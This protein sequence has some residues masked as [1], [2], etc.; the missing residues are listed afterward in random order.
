LVLFQV[1]VK[2]ENFSQISSDSDH[3]WLLKTSLSG[4]SDHTSYLQALPDIDLPVVVPTRAITA[5]PAAGYP[6][7]FITPSTLP[8]VAGQAPGTYTVWTRT[9]APNA[10]GDSL[11]VGLDGPFGSTQDKQLVGVTGVEPGQ[12]AWANERLPA[13]QAATLSIETGGLYTLTASMRED[14]LRLDRLV[15]TTD[16]TPSVPTGEGPL[17]TTRQLTAATTTTALTRTIVYTYD[18]LSRLTAVDYST[19]ESFAY[20]YDPLG[21]QTALTETVD[22]SDTVVTTYTYNAA[23]QLVH[24]GINKP[25][26]HVTLRRSRSVSGAA[27]QRPFVA[28][29]VT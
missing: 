23:N 20:A 12:W 5:A 29:R 11:Y 14:G 18:K 26:V 16:T 19:G 10:A 1:V 21:N 7:Q 24:Q 9:N 25:T 3:D 2:A 4:T 8:L 15:L 13:G 6:I 27:G 22:L 17:E 28:L